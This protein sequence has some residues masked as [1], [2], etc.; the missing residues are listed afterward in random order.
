MAA[1]LGFK[2]FT[3]GEVLSAG[4][5]NGY[6]MQ[7]VLVFASAAARDAA[8]TSP[9]EGQACYL[10]DTDAVMTYSG[11]AWVAVGGTVSFNTGTN[12]VATSQSTT[13]TTYVGLT[14]AQAVTVTTGTKALVS[15]SA[16]F[17]NAAGVNVGARMSFAISGATTVAAADQFSTGIALLASAGGNYQVKNGGT[18]LVTGLTAGSNVFT[19]QFR[20]GAGDTPGFAE[21]TINVVNLGS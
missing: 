11:S 18:F 16:T 10:K 20:K 4:D 19:A 21:R 14:T 9:Q 12:Y 6:L 17:E 2:T 5:T 13:S 3:T 8:I 15:I 7:G 1:G